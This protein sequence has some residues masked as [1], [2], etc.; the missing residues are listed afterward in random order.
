MEVLFLF[1]EQQRTL[2]VSEIARAL[3]IPLPSAY[4]IVNT[5]LDGGFLER[6]TPR[7]PVRLGLRLIRLG[8]LA[9]S[10]IELREVARPVLNRLAV[11]VGETAILMV[12]SDSGA[13]CIDHVEGTYPIRPASFTVGQVQPYNAGA[14]PLV[15]LA[16]LPEERRQ[17]VLASPL[18]VFT[19]FT[20]VTAAAVNDRCTDIR[21]AG[22]AYSEDEV[23]VGTSAVA[24]PVFGVTGIVGGVGLTGIADRVVGLEETIREAA[25][26]I[27]TGLGG[28]FPM[29]PR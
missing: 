7:G 5:L 14:V 27:S 12:P 6:P 22:I 16:Y 18:P 28:S 4:R 29:E 23:I 25:K 19:N 1:S 15:I 8:W 11:E 9:Q 21:Q 26:E 20:L 2:T 10:G 13:V 3:D 24:A 17:Q